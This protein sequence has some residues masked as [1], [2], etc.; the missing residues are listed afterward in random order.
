M[1]ALFSQA[2]HANCSFQQAVQTLHMDLLLDS[3]T[4]LS[5]FLL[6]LLVALKFLELV[7]HNTCRITPTFS[8]VAANDKSQ[9]A[10]AAHNVPTNNGKN[11]SRMT[12]WWEEK[13]TD[14]LRLLVASTAASMTSCHASPVSNCEHVEL[15]RTQC[16]DAHVPT[17]PASTWCTQE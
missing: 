10:T 8:C 13:Y 11:R 17:V 1:L 14:A 6:L 16:M 5:P 3:R 12:K 15:L 4:S 7:T 2:A 9:H